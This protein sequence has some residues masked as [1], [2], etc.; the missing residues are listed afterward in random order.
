ML[1]FITVP[2][3]DIPGKL[4]DTR[5][6]LRRGSGGVRSYIMLPWYVGNFTDPEKAISA[7]VAAMFNSYEAEERRA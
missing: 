2:P 6:L 7:I 3:V 1:P 4:P 5:W